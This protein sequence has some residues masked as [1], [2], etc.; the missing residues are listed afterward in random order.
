MKFQCP[1]CDASYEV[2][3][4]SLGKT[5]ECRMCGKKSAVL[6]GA[7]AT[8]AREA[9]AREAIAPPP[10]KKITTARPKSRRRKMALLGA[11]LVVLVGLGVFSVVYFSRPLH[12]SDNTQQTGFRRWG[13]YPGKGGAPTTKRSASG[14]DK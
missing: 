12:G 13:Y 11:T 9:M 5:M 14:S 7:E 2:G 1:V 6:V 3:P 8:A 10:V 4:D